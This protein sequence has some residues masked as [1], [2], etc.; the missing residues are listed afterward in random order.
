MKAEMERLGVSRESTFFR[1]EWSQKIKNN[2]ILLLP[3]C[4]FTN[5]ELYIIHTEMRG[6]KFVAARWTQKKC[7]FEIHGSSG[8]NNKRRIYVYILCILNLF[9]AV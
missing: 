6:K 9:I 4:R 8:S 1:M 3:E 5:L 2:K 7:I